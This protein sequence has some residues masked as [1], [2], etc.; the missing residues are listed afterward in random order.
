[1]VQKSTAAALDFSAVT[2]QSARILKKLG[3][4]LPGL[5]DSCLKASRMAW[6]WAKK[7]PRIIYDQQAMNKNFD[8]KITTGAYGDNTLWDE[9]FMGCI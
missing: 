8:I 3:K 4:Q 7:N 2:A 6:N 1:V 9:W 5:S